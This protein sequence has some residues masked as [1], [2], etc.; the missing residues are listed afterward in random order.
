MGTA[1]VFMAAGLAG[2]AG[3]SMVT[4]LAET[5]GASMATGLSETLAKA[6]SSIWPY[7]EVFSDVSL[8]KSLD[9]CK[10]FSGLSLMKLLLAEL[11]SAASVSEVAGS[12][13]A[14]VG[15]VVGSVEAATG[16]TG[17]VAGSVGVS[18]G[19]VETEVG[20]GSSPLLSIL[21]GLATASGVAS[22]PA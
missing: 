20:A 1:G 7:L 8:S 17:S 6:S 14:S 13:G 18:A 4:G 10:T 11:G 3:V 9:G 16:S 2:I 19:S 21:N 5:A 15:A 12:T 22:A